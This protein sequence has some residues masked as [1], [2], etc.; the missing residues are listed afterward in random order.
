MSKKYLAKLTER[1]AVSKDKITSKFGEKMLKRMGWSAGEGLGKTKSGDT[2][3]LQVR[4]R[5]ENLGL[6]SDSSKFKWNHNWW[7]ELFNDTADKI[8][9]SLP[10]K[11]VKLDS[12]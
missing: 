9:L 8:Q 7:E 12:T 6:G 3:P 11:R 5:K 1:S 10:K 4:K 2:E